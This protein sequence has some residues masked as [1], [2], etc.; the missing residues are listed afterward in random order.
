MFQIE[1]IF[2]LLTFEYDNN[3][4]VIDVCDGSEYKQVTMMIS[5]YW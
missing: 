3:G 2:T 5:C 1:Y 4:G